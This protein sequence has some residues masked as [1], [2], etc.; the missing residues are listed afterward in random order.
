[1]INSCIERENGENQGEG[2]LQIGKKLLA[3]GNSYASVTLFMG[4]LRNGESEF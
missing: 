2:D 1:M 4:L 3:S